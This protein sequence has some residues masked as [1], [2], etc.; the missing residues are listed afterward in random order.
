MLE[1]ILKPFFKIRNYWQYVSFNEMAVLYIS[2]N[3]RVFAVKLTSTFSLIYIYKFVHSIW[4]IPV[5]ILIHYIAKFV[6][7]IIA[8]FYIS[9]NG[10]KHGM[11]LANILYIPALVLM[12]S[13]ELFGK[14]LGLIVALTGVIFKGISV[15][16][17]NLSYNVNF[18]KA[19]NVKK[20]GKQLGWAYILENLS[21]S[22][23][24]ALVVFL[25]YFLV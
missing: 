5:C 20:V 15:S 10:P 24:P 6:G 2:K 17:E 22:I 3:M 21:S 7:S 23:T 8:L 16:I 13:M 19:K 4:I 11:L 18:S 9:K 1:K 14:D 12:A 25:R